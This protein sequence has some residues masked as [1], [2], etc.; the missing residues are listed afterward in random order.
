MIAMINTVERCWP[1][2]AKLKLERE[3]DT[4]TMTSIIEKLLPNTQRREWTLY[5]Q[6][7][8]QCNPEF[9]EESERN[10]D[11]KF[12]LLLKFML[13]GMRWSI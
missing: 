8:L 2:L 11:G 1:D 6:N 10:P 12:E 4:S 3:M 7:A 13:N 5:K 9:T